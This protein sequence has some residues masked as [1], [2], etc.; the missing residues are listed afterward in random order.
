[1]V[2]KFADYES[3]NYVEK[4]GTYEFEV[5]D[6]ELKDGKEFPCAVF[7]VKSDAGKSTV[8]CSLSPKARFNY[9]S[10]IAACLNLTPEQRKTFELDYEIIGQQLVGKHFLGE[11]VCESY[12]KEVKTMNDDG[13]MSTDI[14]KK[15]GYKIKKF[16]SV[17]G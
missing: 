7:E 1:M 13:T 15:D 12:D 8:Y 9:N 16:Y 2:E 6:Y 5:T 11:V 3:V 10:F 4:E 17:E 14:V